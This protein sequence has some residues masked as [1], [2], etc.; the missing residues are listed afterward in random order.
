MTEP[1]PTDAP[2]LPD[3][4]AVRAAYDRFAEVY[5][6]HWGDVMTG[7]VLALVERFVA[8]SSASV[9]G[10]AERPLRLLDLC[11]G[12][13]QLAAALAARGHEVVGIDASAGLLA[14]ARRRAPSARLLRQD[15]REL[16]LE[17]PVDGA[18]CAF[19]SLNH[20]PDLASLRQV[21]RR[22]HDHLRPGGP[23]L[24]DL[25]M[26]QGFR[27]RF[28]EDFAITT[29]ALVLTVRGSFDGA[30]GSYDMTWL[31][32]E[33][34]DP[35]LWRRQDVRLD[36][37]CYA[38]AEVREQLEAVG[39]ALERVLDAEKEADMPGHVGRR[40]F[41]ARRPEPLR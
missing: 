5:D 38:E 31:S 12:S 11:C 20:L 7:P 17:A 10:S 1:S 23:F 2:I 22:V 18:I 40:F 24:F 9:E 33:P 3:P 35:T 39:F 36:Q 16:A 41:L 6:R 30:I 19:D 27:E 13:G 15:V 26:D 4:Q 37:R 8:P 29:D 25:N 21:F 14:H 32:P 28:A 34:E